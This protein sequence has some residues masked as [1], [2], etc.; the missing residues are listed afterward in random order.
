[1]R[2]KELSETNLTLSNTAWRQSFST[3]NVPSLLTDVLNHDHLAYLQYHFESIQKSTLPN[4]LDIH[5]VTLT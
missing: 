2:T 1:M 3:K 5:F 4:V